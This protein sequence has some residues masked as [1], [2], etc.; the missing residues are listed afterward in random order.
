MQF[1]SAML[2]D[3]ELSAT[4]RLLIKSTL[5]RDMPWKQSKSSETDKLK[6]ACN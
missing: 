2:T 4:N 1:F 3:Y 5:Y 6:M